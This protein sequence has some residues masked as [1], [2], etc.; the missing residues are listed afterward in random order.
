MTALLLAISLAQYTP[1]EAQALF[2]EA[3]DAYHRGDHAAAQAKYEKLLMAGFDGPDVLFNLGT[4]ALAADQL[5]AAVLYLERAK[6]VADDEDIEANLAV[7]LQRQ[8]D[9]VVGDE[10]AVPFTTRLAD[11]LDEHLASIGFLA[12]WW[13]GFGLLIVTWRRRPGARLALGLATSTVLL[14]SSVLG[15]AVA[16]HAYVRQ[17]VTEGIVVAP[18]SKVL[19]FPGDSAKTA[20]EVH[21]G[22]KVRL[23][24]T[25][26]KFVRIRLPNALEGWISTDAV[27][28]L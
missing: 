19:E 20:F 15:C 8:V 4:T 18:S 1:S 7:A 5:G 16:I 23:I 6:R 24:E 11:A 26:G 12:L 13:L 28:E 9:Q 17:R 21:A 27:V 2:A 3:N 22:L 25:S 14:G 10:K